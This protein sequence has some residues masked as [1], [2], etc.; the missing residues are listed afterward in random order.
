MDADSDLLRRQL[1]AGQTDVGKH[2]RIEW[3]DKSE[4]HIG[5]AFIVWFGQMLKDK[6]YFMKA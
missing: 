2:S 4:Y 6:H 5:H 3:H 1:K